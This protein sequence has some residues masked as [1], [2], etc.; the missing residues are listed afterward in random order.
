MTPTPAGCEK[1][2]A[3]HLIADGRAQVVDVFSECLVRELAHAQ[4]PHTER[5]TRAHVHSAVGAAAE[6]SLL[7]RHERAQV[8]AR[9]GRP[10]R[11]TGRR[12]LADAKDAAGRFLVITGDSDFVVPVRSSRKV[13]DLLDAELR[14]LAETGHLPMDEKPGDVAALLL[15]FM[16][17]T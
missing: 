4:P 15:D 5:S 16:G 7:R 3:G 6:A 2:H 1:C 17:K 8:G 14:E 9:R 11:E 13:A 12:L 10:Q